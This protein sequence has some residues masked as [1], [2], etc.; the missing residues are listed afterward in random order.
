MEASVAMSAL[1]LVLHGATETSVASV[2][3][4]P[5]LCGALS[6]FLLREDEKTAL[7]RLRSGFVAPTEKFDADAALWAPHMRVKA[8][9]RKLY[10]D[11]RFRG[12][13]RFD[14]A[15]SRLAD[16]NLRSLKSVQKM[17]GISSWSR[18]RRP[19]DR[20][21]RKNEILKQLSVNDDTTSLDLEDV[22]EAGGA[23]VFGHNEFN[24]YCSTFN[25]YEFLTSN[26]VDELVKFIK[27][28]HHSS[29]TSPLLEIGAGDGSLSH[30][31]QV[32]GGLQCIATDSGAWRI[33]PRYSVERLDA[34]RALE[35]YR[36]SFVVASWMPDQVD[37]TQLIRDT[38]S[39]QAY[40]LIG[41]TTC[42]GH[43]WLTWGE[44]G[45]GDDSHPPPY[46]RDGFQRIDSED[47]HRL[48]LSQ[49]DSKAFL[50]TSETV[51]FRRVVTCDR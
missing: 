32:S 16:G 12:T 13:E 39:V 6:S 7:S 9:I 29:S 51:L 15:A 27:E 17:F 34:K 22:L 5:L 47:C 36:P 24:A 45:E 4:A 46:A 28:H 40:L 37:W 50:G 21:L 18:D 30:H 42:C 2:H 35:K 3:V 26:Y 33:A 23:C 25:I 11:A 43:P 20:D 44:H 14:E 48:Q 41:P 1:R 49:Y 31:L 19:E 38:E 8:G 10:I